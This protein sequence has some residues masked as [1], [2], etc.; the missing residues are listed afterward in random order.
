MTPGFRPQVDMKMWWN[1][2]KRR[3]ATGKRKS[4]PAKAGAGAP[5][6]SGWRRVVYWGAVAGIWTTVAGLFF[7]LYLAHDLPDLGNLPPPAGAERIEVRGNDGELIASYG[8]VYGD[9]LDFEQI[10]GILIDA[11]VAIEDR[12]FFGHRGVDARAVGRALFANVRAG[13][14]RQGASTITQQLAKNL[15][16]SPERTLKRKAQELL[17]AAW[18]E[19]RFSKETILTIYLN[20]IYFGGGTYGLDAASQKF[21]DHSARRLSLGEAALLAGVIQAPSRYTP[22]RSATRAYGRMAEVLTAMASE[23]Y[24]TPADAGMVKKKAAPDCAW[25]Q[26]IGGTLFHGL[27]NRKGADP[28]AASRRVLNYLYQP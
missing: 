14:I 10:P 3:V 20:R 13:R 23:G 18:I 19:A 6:R 2:T 5:V 28:G 16:L 22:S 1:K 8:A 26:R 12:R 4:R 17:L 15:Y 27:D 11:V 24:V 25:R 9:W 7:V 21:F